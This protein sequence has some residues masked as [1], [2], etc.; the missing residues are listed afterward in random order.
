MSFKGQAQ[1]AG[2]QH[3]L[4]AHMVTRHGIGNLTAKPFAGP[5]QRAIYG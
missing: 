2:I 4:N 5:Q 1:F 3:A